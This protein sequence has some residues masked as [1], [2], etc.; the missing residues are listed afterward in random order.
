MKNKH[1]DLSGS[2]ESSTTRQDASASLPPIK[3]PRR[4][5]DYGAIAVAA[6][7]KAVLE[8]ERKT[9]LLGLSSRTAAE[10]AELDSLL[11]GGA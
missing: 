3:R 7:N 8:S 1:D 10:Q 11:A 6:L 4:D 2:N 9:Y 5:I